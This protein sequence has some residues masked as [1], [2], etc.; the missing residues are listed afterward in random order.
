MNSSLPEIKPLTSL[1]FILA[2]WVVLYHYREILNQLIPSFKHL[3]WITA[4]GGYAVPIF[5]ILSGF[6]ISYNYLDK[7]KKIDYLQFVWKRFARLWPVHFAVIILFFALFFL[8]ENWA[9]I[10][11]VIISRLAICFSSCSWSGLGS[12]PFC[13]STSQQ[14][15]S[16]VNGLHIFWF[17]P[18]VFWFSDSDGQMLPCLRSLLFSL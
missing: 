8:Q 17:F 12:N 14:G 3:D 1:R 4:K 15:P 16:S 2:M 6:I 7:F 13:S 10:S 18:P 9:F 5:F 11:T